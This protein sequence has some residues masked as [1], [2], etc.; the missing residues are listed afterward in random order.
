MH[1]RYNNIIIAIRGAAIAS[2]DQILNKCTPLNEC[3]RVDWSDVESSVYH[4]GIAKGSRYSWCIRVATLSV[5]YFNIVLIVLSAV[6][7]AIKVGIEISF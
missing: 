7:L 1:L 3:S 2:Q 4:S 5:H 6:Q